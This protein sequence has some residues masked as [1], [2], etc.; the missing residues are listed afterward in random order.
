MRTA[1]WAPVCVSVSRPRGPTNIDRRAVL[2]G[3]AALGLMAVTSQAA[4]RT[5]AQIKDDWAWLGRYADENQQV[6]KADI[7]VEIVFLGDSITENWKKLN[8]AFFRPGWICRGISGQTTPQMVLRMASDVVA[9]K[10]KLVHI[11]AGTN[12]IAGN[13]GSMTIEMTMANVRAMAA[14]AKDVGIGVIVGSVPPAAQFGWRPEVRPAIKI[15]EL[16]R[17]LKAFAQEKGFGWIDYHAALDDGTGGLGSV[18]SKDGVHPNPAGYKV[19]EDQAMPTIVRMIKKPSGGR[20]KN[21]K[22]H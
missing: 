8:P 3:S 15:I 21:R 10:P 7:P 17:S 14:I 4:P 13:T 9:L 20:F 11:L 6:L 5:E 16:N 2:L 12:D 19:M 22:D 1:T 18:H